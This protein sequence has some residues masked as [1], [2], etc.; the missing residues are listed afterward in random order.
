[1]S[2]TQSPISVTTSVTPAEDHHFHQ[3]T[4]A[5]SEAS[6]RSLDAALT[7]TSQQAAAV[8]T[9]ITLTTDF[10]DQDALL[11][12]L[13][14]SDRSDRPIVNKHLAR[15][16]AADM[17]I[18]SPLSYSWSESSMQDSNT[19]MSIS[20]DTDLTSDQ[21]LEGGLSSSQE[22]QKPSQKAAGGPFGVQDTAS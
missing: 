9:P 6:A 5:V 13:T 1:M 8:E 14:R 15:I 18:S 19:S 12:Y 2:H 3:P 16:S 7:A 20:F 17:G 21:M 22:G 10:D 4:S 11:D